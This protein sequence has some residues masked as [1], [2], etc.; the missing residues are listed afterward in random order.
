MPYG[1]GGGNFVPVPL[2]SNQTSVPEIFDKLLTDTGHEALLL[3]SPKGV[4]HYASPSSDAVIGIMAIQGK[5]L[6][7]MMPDDDASA[8]L[9]GFRDAVLRGVPL[10]PRTVRLGDKHVVI[11]T[12]PIKDSM[13]K[14]IELQST[15]RDVSEF[16]ILREQIQIQESV[17]LAAN[18]MA[19]VG[20]WRLEV[21]SQQLFWSGE[22]R[23]IHQVPDDYVPTVETAINFYEAD[24]R[25]VVVKA[26]ADAIEL[27]VRQDFELPLVTYTGKHIWVRV[28]IMPEV[29][30]DTVVRIYGAFQDISVLHQREEQ[31]S[32]MV[33]EVTK[34]RDQ[35]EE[36]AYVISHHLRGP[37]GNI[38]SLLSALSEDDGLPQAPD[39]VRHLRESA[40]LLLDT[41]EDLTHAI[42]VRHEETP[43]IEPINIASVIDSVVKGLDEMIRASNAKINVDVSAF[44]SMR[45]AHE[46]LETILRQLIT[47]A[48]RFSAFKPESS[49]TRDRLTGQA[50]RSHWPRRLLGGYAG[51]AQQRLS[52]N[53][54]VQNLQ[55]PKVKE[56]KQQQ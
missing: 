33:V 54:V 10:L 8:V 14:V 12:M 31:L 44:P 45:Y 2:L 19:Q 13:G 22:V 39:T 50:F 16:V 38:V 30:N 18:E 15:V 6:I 37:V 5:N 26:V 24:Q 36:F 41:L 27:A 55:C 4:V 42:I 23:K 56:I 51:V 1:L 20:A 29:V 21:A 7:E 43:N 47:N 35:L 40:R 17:A 53:F 49:A 32:R 3:H 9:T 34:Q 11:M 52:M 46:Y 48:I 25:H 28:S